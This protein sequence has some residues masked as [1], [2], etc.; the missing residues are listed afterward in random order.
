MSSRN[1]SLATS[2]HDLPMFHDGAIH[3]THQKCSKC[4]VIQRTHAIKLRSCARCHQAMYCSKECQTK[5]WPTHKGK[6]K[7]LERERAEIQ[8]KTGLTSLVDDVYA[9]MDYYDTPLKNCA[10]AAMRLPENPHMERKA[11]LFLQIQYEEDHADLP[12]HR[13]F[14][15]ISVGRPYMNDLPL[16]SVLRK[17][18]AQ[19][20][21]MCDRGRIELG[22][23]FYGVGRV[24]IDVCVGGTSV[25][26]ERLKHFSIDTETAPANIVR[27]DWWVLFRE[28]V[29]LGARIKFCCGKMGGVDDICCCGGWVHDDEKRE[30][31]QNVGK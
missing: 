18:A 4:L 25:V 30:A 14:S 24:G 5:D 8:L 22:D 9:W 17:T 15:I 16:Q 7:A 10:I 23:R 28:Y 27:Q 26:T 31:F 20:S 29:A 21:Q 13:K 2:T 19:Y 1:P 3:H 6:C 11:L 12:A